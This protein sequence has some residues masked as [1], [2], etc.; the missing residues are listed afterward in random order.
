MLANEQVVD[1]LCDR[2]D[3]TVVQKALEQWFF[4]ITDYAQRLLDE[5]N[6]PRVL[7]PGGL[8]ILGH[9]KRDTLEVPAFWKEH[10]QLKHGDTVIRFFKPGTPTT[11]SGSPS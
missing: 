9:T 6:L 11:V 7:A 5:P 3:S 10:R 8:F 2:C 1:G 4:K